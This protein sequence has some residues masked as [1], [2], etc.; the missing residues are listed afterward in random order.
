MSAL[1]RK[2][3]P[4]NIGQKPTQSQKLSYVADKLGL[5]GIKEMQGTTFNLFDTVLLNTNLTGRQL[6][7]FFSDTGNKSRNFSNFQNGTLGAGEAMVIES[8]SFWL[9]SLSATNLSLPATTITG[10]WPLS[11][12]LIAGGASVTLKDALM[13]GL[14]NLSIANV[15]VV[16][17]L[18]TFEQ[19]PNYNPKTTGIA[20]GEIV[21][22][23]T[24][25]VDLF[26]TQVVGQN[27]IMLESPPVLPPNQA[28]ELTVEYPPVGT[29]TGNLAIMCSVGRFG[30]I[31][32]AKTTL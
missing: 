13:L 4:S 5:T 9:V 1:R 27:T 6:L 3:R 12:T 17:D 7:S 23:D 26:P 21:A 16:K 8:V 20:V 2:P 19:D 10:K 22:G 28:F 31:F 14:L 11:Q 29:V 15:R 30:S 25:P 18:L 32:S 24:V